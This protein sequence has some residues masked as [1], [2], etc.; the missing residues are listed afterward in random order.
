MKLFLFIIYQKVVILHP[1][2]SKMIFWAKWI[3]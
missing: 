3:A 1:K 2:Y